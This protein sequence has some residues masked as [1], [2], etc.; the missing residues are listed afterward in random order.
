MDE[1]NKTIITIIQEVIKVFHNLDS[2]SEFI[3][4]RTSHWIRIF[5]ANNI[6]EEFLDVIVLQR[7]SG[8]PDT[9]VIIKA[10][11]EYILP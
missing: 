10:L 7:A 3:K 9:D 4:P 5:D 11:I 1:R 8:K 2:C 6:R